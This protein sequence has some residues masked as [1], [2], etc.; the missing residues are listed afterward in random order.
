MK[1]LKFG[2]F[3]IED[4][5]SEDW[6]VLAPIPKT[7]NNQE[8]KD[9]A[10]FLALDF[11]LSY[12]GY[13]TDLECDDFFVIHKQFL[14][15]ELVTTI[16][17]SDL[18][19]KYKN[20]S[21]KNAADYEDTYWEEEVEGWAKSIMKPSFLKSIGGN[22]AGNIVNHFLTVGLCPN[23]GVDL[24]VY[25]KGTTQDQVNDF[26]MAFHKLYNYLFIRSTGYAPFHGQIDLLKKIG[27][28]IIDDGKE[29]N[30]RTVVFKVFNGE[31]YSEGGLEANVCEARR[32]MNIIYNQKPDMN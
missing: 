10:E 15:C 12:E 17:L 25:K 26:I 20:Q 6:F 4:G 8:G 7:V 11:F 14:N 32:I 18:P 13:D 16:K 23:D 9:I 27:F 2:V 30:V 29:S 24:D 28:T 22:D 3:W 5:G 31:V 19:P 21:K 1:G